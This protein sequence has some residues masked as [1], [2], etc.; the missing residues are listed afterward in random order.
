MDRIEG[1]YEILEKMQEGGMGAVYKVRHRHLDEVRVIKMMRPHLAQDETLR[2][3]FK[4]EAK[5]AIRLRHRNLAQL[6]DFTVDE[7]GNSFIVMEYIAGANLLEVMKVLVR[8]SM[9]MV[10]EIAQQSL[11]VIGYLHKRGIIHRDISPDNIMLSRD[12]DREPIV[13]L[14]D[15]G[16]A[17]EAKSDS[18][19]TVAGTFLGKVRYSSPEQLKTQDGVDVEARSDLYSFAIVL[20]QMLTT[21]Y[22]IRGT[23][24]TAVIAGHLMQPPVPFSESDPQGI[25]PKD[26]R[27][28]VISSLAKKPE[29][30]PES[31][32]VFRKAVKKVQKDY[33]FDPDELTRALDAP[34]QTTQRIEIPRPGSTQD[35]LDRQ[36]GI[37]TTPPPEDSNVPQK[38]PPPLP[39]VTEREPSKQIRALLLGAE[40]LME[41]NHLDEARLQ[42]QTAREIDPDSSEVTRL[43]EAVGRLSEAIDGHRAKAAEKV[44]NLISHGE[45]DRAEQSLHAAIE[46][47]GSDKLLDEAA[48]QLDEEKAEVE[49]KRL[50]AEKAFDA[51]QKAVEQNELERGIS[52]LSEALELDPQHKGAKSRLAEVE[53][54]RAKQIEEQ[55]KSQEI[56]ETCREIAVQIENG[57]LDE[58]ERALAVA[59]KVYGAVPEFDTLSADRDAA[60]I[61]SITSEATQLIADSEFSEA[62]ETLSRSLKR[63]GDNPGLSKLLQQAE[64]ALAQQQQE[65]LRLEAIQSAVQSI[66]RLQR[67]G[68]L[69][70]A[71][72]TLERTINDHGKFDGAEALGVKI[73][74]AIE[75]RREQEQQAYAL[76]EQCRSAIKNGEFDEGQAALQAARDLGLD[77]PNVTDLIEQTDNALASQQMRVRR[78]KEIRQ[79]AKSI[80]ACLKSGDLPR[81]ERELQV[82]ERL[83]GD[84]AELHTLHLQF[85]DL[86]LAERKASV[87]NLLRD[88]LTK[89]TS[90]PEVISVLEKALEID[91]ENTKALRLLAE[92]RAAHNRFLQ[93]RRT[94][95]ISEAMS[96]I[97]DLVVKGKMTEALRSLE[98]TVE[99]VGEFREAK[100]LRNRLKKAM[101]E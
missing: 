87:E 84:C 97:D 94:R 66:E 7:D 38:S 13:K 4:R 20:Y 63:L 44:R 101:E 78:E 14:I 80:A 51:A 98:E 37:G 61:Q 6:Y 15:L 100:A 90:F 88:A 48:A 24:T 99:K 60:E 45:L 29:N 42:L 34:R 55:R 31:A 96:E 19:L 54:L 71:Y 93:E 43:S 8:P 49:A 74:S 11:D 58:A 47:Y 16:I 77:N 89:Q 2:E 81:A 69:E 73:K 5:T 22:P 92:T 18:G 33:S 68:R 53:A 95:R 86:Q 83:F 76:L 30:R 65:Q 56:V 70:T 64:A 91:P 3:R 1:K 67:I 79:A 23:S 75:Q 25:V 62:A 35:Q 12:E 72:R 85:E 52:L 36:F 39:G 10:L 40:K 41:A 59:R 17:K 9:A 27:D 82:A 50:K 57:D 46:S 21:K 28:L 32:L 26:L